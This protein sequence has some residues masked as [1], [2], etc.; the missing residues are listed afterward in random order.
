VRRPWIRFAL[1]LAGVAVVA[2]VALALLDV[3][4]IKSRLDSGQRQISDLDLDAASAPKGLTTASAAA[5]SSL[6]SADDLA[7]SSPWLGVLDRIPVV[8][9]Q[10]DGLREM[11]GATAELGHL[12]RDAAGRIE[13]ALDAASGNPPGRVALLDVTIEELNAV[14]AR[15]ATLHPAAG[16]TLVPPLSSA[17][18]HLL[19][20]LSEA[21]TKLAQ[22]TDSATALR[23]FFAGPTKI[24]LLAGNNAEMVAGSGMPN[25][26]GVATIANGDIDLGEFVQNDRTFLQG[27]YGVPISPDLLSLYGPIGLGYDFRGTTA[28]PNFPV[29]AEIIHRMAAIAPLFGPV[30]GVFV[31]D[32][33]VIR[34][35]LEVAGPVEVEGTTYSA[36]TVMQAVLNDNYLRF[37][38]IKEDRGSRANLQGAIARAAF[39]AIKTRHVELTALVKRLAD[40]AKGRHFLA[41]S[42]DPTLEKVFHDIHADGSVPADGLIV[43]PENFG[44]NKLDW[45]LQPRLDVGVTRDPSNAYLINLTLTI[46]NDPRSPTTEQ[47]EG[48]TPGQHFVFADVHAPVNA[49]DLMSFDKPWIATGSDPPMIAANFIDDIPLGTTKS[50]RF[51]FRLPADQQALRILP[52]ARVHPT[53]ISVNGLPTD[54]RVQVDLYLPGLAP[55]VS[56]APLSEGVAAGFVVAI[57]GFGFALSSLAGR[58]GAPALAVHQLGDPPRRS[59][60]D[61]LAATWL[62]S[63]ATAIIL[64]QALWSSR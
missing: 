39:D 33:F 24:L 57:F 49:L 7:H 30:D 51:S 19:D 23:T 14:A 43:S 17:R 63:G 20:K 15:V 8:G 35:L 3:L 60:F 58:K 16:R 54:D 26:G 34:D 52:S 6:D 59:Q 22:A 10:I 29:A 27:T 40:A 9:S 41:W 53:Q 47:V 48:L 37:G 1:A 46:A 11:T 62:L 36:D 50:W 25:S 12:A 42:A 28:T 56:H 64:A 18:D 55:P 44:G 61:A 13:T 4:R 45:Y 38:D 21:S 31:V 5:A 32:V 2:F